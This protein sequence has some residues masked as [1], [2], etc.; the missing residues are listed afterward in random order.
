MRVPRFRLNRRLRARLR[1]QRSW[2]RGQWL[3]S[4]RR[5]VLFPTLGR[6]MVAVETLVG[7]AHP[8]VL[9]EPPDS[10]PLEPPADEAAAAVAAGP[11]IAVLHATAGNGHKRAAEALAAAVA[12]LEAH[13]TV[14]EVDTLVFA[15]RLYRGTYAASYNAM[16]RHAPRLWGALYHSWA[17][18]PVNRGTAPVRLALDRLNLRRLVRVVERERPDAVVCTHFLPVEALSPGR[19]RGLG[20]PLHCVITD[21][22]AHPFWAFPHVDRYFVAADAVADELAGHGVS[23]RRIEVTGIPVDPRF[24]LRIGRE[25][26]CARFGLDPD[27]PVVLVMGGGRGVGPLGELAERL[28][29]LTRGMQVL[30]VCGTNARLRDGIDRLPAGRTGRIR[31]LGFTDEV[32]V[33]LEACDAVVSKA[34]GLTC[35][36]A[37]VKGAPLVV[38]R[39]T[40]G[41]EVRN[42]RFLASAGAAV[43]ADSADEVLATLAHW[44][45]DP[46]ARARVREAQARIARPDAAAAI[47]RRVM[48]DIHAAGASG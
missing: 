26:A 48:G 12:E 11:R 10:A 41:Q 19:G 6:G 22:A 7:P 34:G 4:A 33:L 28:A 37:L 20:A 9:L 38:F 15:S 5:E 45:A 24:A 23:R 31:T 32:D 43:H 16:A 17:M 21:F 1:A 2:W 27:R 30:V 25:A 47:A 40:P 13:A 14:R 29:A 44:V 46:G 3:G 35:S 18:A 36:E 42:A 39:P 8:G